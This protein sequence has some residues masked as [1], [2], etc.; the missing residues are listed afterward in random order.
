MTESRDPISFANFARDDLTRAR[1]ALTSF[2]HPA[3]SVAEVAYVIHGDRG[4]GRE[5]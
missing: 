3:F 4:R 2:I 5:L 1:I